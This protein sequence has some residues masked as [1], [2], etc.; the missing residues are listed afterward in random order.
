MADLKFL[1]A[2]KTAANGK[3]GIH[4]SKDS[5][6]KPGFQSC[7][8]KLFPSAGQEVEGAHTPERELTMTDVEYGQSA[9]SLLACFNDN[10]SLP[11][12]AISLVSGAGGRVTTCALNTGLQMLLRSH[13]G[14]SQ[15]RTDNTGLLHPATATNSE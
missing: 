5:P 14:Q 8:K 1:P 10:P 6:W 11:A 2:G 15:P 12:Q 4:V 3:R 7:L 9:A 13:L